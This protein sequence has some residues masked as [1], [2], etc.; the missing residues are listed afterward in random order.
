MFEAEHKR[1]ISTYFSGVQLDSKF[2]LHYNPLRMDKPPYCDIGRNNVLKLENEIF[3]II[4]NSGAK[5]LSFTI[6]LEDHY[7]FYKKHPVNPLAYGLICLLER[8]RYY[9][10]DNDIKSTKVIYERFTTGLRDMVYKEQNFLKGTEFKASLDLNKLFR[11]I[12]NGDPIKE[13]VL[14]FADFWAY[15]PYIKEKGLLEIEKNYSNQYYNYNTEK[16]RGNV[17]IRY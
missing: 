1:L 15:L 13:L 3:S 4:K 6:D 10:R 17:T 9:M 8:L 11:Y 5:L 7:K 12:Y 16:K 2:K 14:Q